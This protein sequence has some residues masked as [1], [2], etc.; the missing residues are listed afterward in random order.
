MC[1]FESCHILGKLGNLAGGVREF[2]LR[3]RVCVCK[4]ERNKQH[5][6]TRL[7]VSMCVCIRAFMR[8][9][10]YAYD[11]YMTSTLPHILREIGGSMP[12]CV[13]PRIYG[14]VSVRVHLFVYA[15]T[16]VS[17]SSV[18]CVCALTLQHTA[19][20]CNTL[21]HWRTYDVYA[22][23]ELRHTATHIVCVC[24]CARVLCVCAC[25]ACPSY[26]CV[27]CAICVTLQHISC[28][29]VHA[30]VCTFSLC[31]CMLCV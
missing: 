6:P 1:I 5:A 17:S 2:V 28:A 13:Y 12:M 30:C 26:V 27:L 3:V 14:Y 29:C 24:A 19:T 11:A 18:M 25:C 4:C 10:Q 22:I 7:G 16:L 21:Q 15:P 20:H 8:T 9:H 31:V 23:C